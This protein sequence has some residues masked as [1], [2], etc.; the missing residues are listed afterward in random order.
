M[1]ARKIKGVISR[2]ESDKTYWKYELRNSI[3]EREAI[4][5]EVEA[6]ELDLQ[7]ENIRGYISGLDRALDKLKMLSESID[8]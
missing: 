8:K 2:I 4:D 5:T 6:Y 1:N 3:D 7:I